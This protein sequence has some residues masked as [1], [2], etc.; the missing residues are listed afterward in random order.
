[1]NNNINKVTSHASSSVVPEQIRTEQ[2]EDRSQFASRKIQSR[3]GFNYF[4]QRGDNMLIAG[5]KTVYNFTV[6]R[7]IPR[8]SYFTDDQAFSRSE[9]LAPEKLE[10]AEAGIKNGHSHEVGSR[11]YSQDADKGIVMVTGVSNETINMSLKRLAGDKAGNNEETFEGERPHTLRIGDKKLSFYKMDISGN[12]A[13]N[14]EGQMA[15]RTEKADK[16]RGCLMCIEVE[17][18]GLKGNVKESI[19]KTVRQLP[20]GSDGRPDISNIRFVLSNAQ[21]PDDIP[22]FKA[23]IE[24]LISKTYGAGKL[25]L[26]PENWIILGT[27]VEGEDESYLTTP[28][29]IKARLA[30]DNQPSPGLAKLPPEELKKAEEDIKNAC[31]HEVSSYSYRQDRHKGIVMVT[32]ASNE[33]MNASLRHLAGNRAE[34]SGKVFEGENP[35]VISIG[36]EKLPFY[37]LA[38]SGNSAENTEN[39]MVDWTEKVNN[40]GGC[41]MC[42][43]TG[44]GSLK[45][46][47]RDSILKTVRQLPPGRDG[48]P[49]ISKVR[50]VL[51]NAKNPDDIPKFKAR[52]ER[53]I[54]K[55]YGAGNLELLPENWIILGKDVED[56]NY[57]TGFEDIRARLTEL[58]VKRSDVI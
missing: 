46:N 19:L 34:D 5:L 7:L 29:V 32:G 20:H 26:L 27:G 3:A 53:L 50:F 58:P 48:L 17:P 15:A 24:R 12:P 43:D 13:Q 30:M 22:K 51:S 4:K 42:I 57:L 55:T 14:A 38:V 40:A 41:L 39:Q 36:G 33:T 44:S 1:M 18:G 47:V 49:D 9:Q 6:A 25:N 45:N 16:T 31:S 10:K 35:H 54:N 28:E 8:G 21:N 23:R 11:S 56:E 52:I 37:K 2:G